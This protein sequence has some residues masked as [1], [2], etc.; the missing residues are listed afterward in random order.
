MADLTFDIELPSGET[1]PVTVPETATKDE[2]QTAIK[3]E[4]N[5]RQRTA[6]A[7]KFRQEAKDAYTSK[8]QE[9]GMLKTAAIG[10]GKGFYNIGRGIQKATGFGGEVPEAETRAVE[11]LKKERPYSFGGGEIV[12]E[13]APFLVGGPAVGGVE[14]LAGRVAAG[15][16]LGA[17]ETGLSEAGKGGDPL[18]GSIIGGVFGA[19]AE[20][21]LP[22]IGSVARKYISEALG[23]TPVVPLID[24]A[25]NPSDELIEALDKV[26]L[27]FG[28]VIEESRREIQ[29]MV[30]DPNQVARM[31][32]FR[33]QGVD[34]TKGQLTQDVKQLAV[35]KALIRRPDM[36]LSGPFI[37]RIADQSRQIKEGILEELP[38]PRAVIDDIATEAQA[39]EAGAAVKQALE[40]VDS[41]LWADKEEFYERSSKIFKQS[42][43]IPLVT[44]E[45]KAALPDAWDWDSLAISDPDGMAKLEKFLR[46]YQVLEPTPDMVEKGLTRPLSLGSFSLLEKDLNALYR[47]SPTMQAVIPKIRRALQ[48]EVDTAISSAQKLNLSPEVVSA[49]SDLRK[50]QDIVKLRKEIFNI[51]ELSGKLLAKH[52]NSVSPMIEASKV[53][54]K[55][56]SKAVPVEQVHSLLSAIS[57][58]P[59]GEGAVAALQ[60]SVLMDLLNSG[61]GKGSKVIQGEPIFNPEA[62]TNRI[63]Q[64]GPAKIRAIFSNNT[65]VL[66][67][68]RNIKNIAGTMP[69]KVPGA[70]SSQPLPLLLAEK[71]GALAIASKIPGVG[72]GGQYFFH[73]LAVAGSSL[74]A[75]ARSKTAI[76]TAVDLKRYEGLLARVYPNLRRVLIP[77]AAQEYS[78]G[79]E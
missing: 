44:D 49:V 3:Q 12:G 76:N 68:I 20:A 28:D 53:Y 30:G 26:G 56:S 36:A 35:E 32:L 71:I 24:A 34:I 15:G 60:T 16:A 11:A 13:T 9:P 58:D 33:Q 67:K 64:I 31:E 47:T 29:G 18:S 23:R 40:G 78:K 27:T 79:E 7:A 66:K 59:G 8:A 45:V 19:A 51:S 46:K 39:T 48:S 10:A 41:R 17:L 77:K 74:Q 75:G 37:D 25:G 38:F 57:R 52:N 50:A 69:S 22:F 21:A 42:D 1:F 65:D 14:A 43:D 63:A 2:L 73:P 55:I 70:V 54:S 4:L 6:Q 72:L 61:F 62:F 5:R